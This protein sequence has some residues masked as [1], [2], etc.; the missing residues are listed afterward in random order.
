MSNTNITYT[1]DQSGISIDVDGEAVDLEK[2]EPVSVPEEVA[3]SLA[4][5]DDITTTQTV[6]KKAQSLVE[7]DDD[8]EEDEEEDDGDDADEGDEA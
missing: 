6:L 3:V 5:R 1:G 4:L 2:G 8:E 7:T